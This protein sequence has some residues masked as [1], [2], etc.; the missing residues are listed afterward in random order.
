MQLGNYT[1]KR[2]IIYKKN[3]SG[4]VTRLFW[5]DNNSSYDKK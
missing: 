3:W 4:P 2:L 1:H 5:T